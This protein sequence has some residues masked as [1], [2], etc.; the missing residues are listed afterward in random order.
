MR[1]VVLTV[2]GA[3]SVAMQPGAVAREGD[4]V[5]QGYAIHVVPPVLAE[6]GMALFLPSRDR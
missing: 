6:P 3:E 1:P 5:S 4:E 2:N